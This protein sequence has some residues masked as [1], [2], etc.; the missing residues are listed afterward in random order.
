MLQLPLLFHNAKQNISS[1]GSH[2]QENQGVNVVANGL[3]S[4]ITS[5]Q[6]IKVGVA[7]Q[8]SNWRISGSC[9][10]RSAYRPYPYSACAVVEAGHPGRKGKH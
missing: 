8:S 6:G 5:H 10:I 1:C 2:S 3:G 9:H 7:Y 4:S